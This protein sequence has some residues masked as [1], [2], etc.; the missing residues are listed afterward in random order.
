[1]RAADL[2]RTVWR[3]SSR[4]DNQGGTCVEVAAVRRPGRA[5]GLRDSKDPAGPVLSFTPSEWNSFLARAKSGA[6]DL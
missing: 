2:T 5:I 6:I 1:M 4:S 3:K